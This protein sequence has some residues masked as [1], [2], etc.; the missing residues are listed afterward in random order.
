MRKFLKIYMKRESGKSDLLTLAESYIFKRVVSDVNKSHEVIGQIFQKK[1]ETNLGR[2]KPF[3][4][5]FFS[6]ADSEMAEIWSN[7]FKV[8]M[9]YLEKALDQYYSPVE[10][11]GDDKS[12]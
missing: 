3:W 5:D 7:S 12:L 2:S 10:L 11:A 4:R 9:L 1:T 6:L 8:D